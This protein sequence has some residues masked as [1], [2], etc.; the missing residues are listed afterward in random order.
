M[1]GGGGGCYLSDANKVLTFSLFFGWRVMLVSLKSMLLRDFSCQSVSDSVEWW[2]QQKTP[3]HQY[4][5][6]RSLHSRPRALTHNNQNSLSAKDMPLKFFFITG[7]IDG[8]NQNKKTYTW[9]SFLYNE[10]NNLAAT[11]NKNQLNLLNVR[12]WVINFDSIH[13]FSSLKALK[14]NTL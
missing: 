8:L 3:K 9:K 10:E 4:T 12:Q 5:D 14:I 2:T 11:D 1:W 13:Q 6:H 7:W